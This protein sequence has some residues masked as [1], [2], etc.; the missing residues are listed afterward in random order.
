[1]KLAYKIP[2]KVTC[3]MVGAM[4]V[5]SCTCKNW[6]GQIDPRRYDGAP[7]AWYDNGILPCPVAELLEKAHKHA[8]DH[9]LEHHNIQRKAAA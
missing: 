3:R 9:V 7:A 6:A 4:F 5:A 8:T 1:M 2:H